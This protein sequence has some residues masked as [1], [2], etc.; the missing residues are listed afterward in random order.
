[1]SPRAYYITVGIIYCKTP[2]EGY[3]MGAT[4]LARATKL[5]RS[6]SNAILDKLNK[7]F[8]PDF[9]LILRSSLDKNF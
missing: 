5:V 7:D 9:L 2:L 6:L 4:E 8:Q 3:T 1:M